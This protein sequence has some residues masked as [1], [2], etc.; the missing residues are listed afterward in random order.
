[1]SE[2]PTSDLSRLYERVRAR[3]EA[4]CTPLEPEDHVPQPVVDVSPPKWHLAHTTWFFETFILAVHAPDHRPLDPR[5]GYLF[6][7]YYEAHGPRVARPNRGALSR[8]TVREVLRYRE[9]VDQ[10]MLGLLTSDPAPAVRTLV[11]LG[12]HHE[13]QHQEL[14]VTDIKAILGRN[15]LQPAYATEST[16]ALDVSVEHAVEAPTEEWLSWDGGLCEIGHAGDDFAFDNEEPRHTTYVPPVELRGDLL[17]NREVL[18][19][20]D[21]G[22]Y[23]RASLWHSEGLDWVRQNAIEAPLYW[24]RDPGAPHGW[25][26]YTLR[27]PEAVDP[28]APATHLSYYEAAAMASRLDAR[29]PTEFEWEAVAPR[30]RT[31]ARWEWTD[32]AYKPYP[33]FRAAPGAVGE[34]NGKFMVN[35]QVLRGASFATPPGHARLTY[36]NFF[37]A[38]LRWQYT[39]VRLARSL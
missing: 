26:H 32:S 39:G 12:L 17:R 30:L 22:G 33:G 1:M 20:I 3:S 25:S 34:Y 24:T 5:Y 13:Q 15:P 28:D 2:L 23:E 35:Q 7:S 16:P 18:D 21:D 14:L 10:A 9:H 19:F 37:H 11:T 6:N 29:L 8:P 36:R 27:G 38:P 31:G 4:L